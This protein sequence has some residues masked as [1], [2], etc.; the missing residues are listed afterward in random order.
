MTI[1][2]AWREG[3]D[4]DEQFLAMPHPGGYISILPP[5]EILKLQEKISAANLSDDDAQD[6]AAGFFAMT[7]TFAFDKQ[8]RVG[9]IPELLGH[10]GIQKDVVLA[11]AGKKFNLYSPSRWEKVEA[12]LKGN[13][14]GD[15]MRRYSI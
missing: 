14:F 5:A 2:S 8:G 4:P 13:G 3:H 11:G 10:A 15:L 6:L 9:L 1:P 12:R 7:Q